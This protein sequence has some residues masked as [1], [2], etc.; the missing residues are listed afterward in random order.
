MS[1]SS[2]GLFDGG[3]ATPKP[4]SPAG[5][6]ALLRCREVVADR[7]AITRRPRMLTPRT[8]LLELVALAEAW[9]PPAPPAPSRRKTTAA[10]LDPLR[11][12][13]AEVAAETI[14][15]LHKD[16]ILKHAESP[17]PE[18]LDDILARWSAPVAAPEEGQERGASVTTERHPSDLPRLRAAADL[19]SRT[20]LDD[21]SL[22]LGQ[23]ARDGGRRMFLL[24]AVCVAI[25]SEL[26]T[27]GWSDPGLR[28]WLAQF[29]AHDV[30]PQLQALTAKRPRALK[31]F[32][33]V[34]GWDPS[35]SLG[36]LSVASLGTR[37]VPD[38]FPEGP[39]VSLTVQ[40][41]DEASAARDAFR[42][43]RRVLDS[44]ALVRPELTASWATP[45]VGVESG[46]FIMSFDV[47][48]WRGS[49]EP[50]DASVAQIMDHPA[51]GAACRYRV[52]AMQVRDPLTRLSLL[53]LGL[54][55]LTALP[56]G[57]VASATLHDLLPR[58]LALH[59]VRT[60][61]EGLARA[62][63]RHPIPAEARIRLG[64]DAGE[65]GE[66]LDRVALLRFLQRASAEEAHRWSQLFPLDV[67]V[68]QW[69]ERTRWHMTGPD[70]DRLGRFFEATRQRIAWQVL[71]LQ[72]AHE[73]VRVDAWPASWIDDLSLHAHNYLTVA[74]LAVMNDPEHLR[75]PSSVL[76]RR[77]GQYDTLLT[78][79]EKSHPRALSA[80]ALMAPLGLVGAE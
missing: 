71:R 11:I 49:V 63:E 31:C 65:E 37:K 46:A 6:L 15:V 68:A 70:P 26:R 30:I 57:D 69:V 75:A 18:M 1:S 56:S 44:V 7:M 22:A 79:L 13:V 14:R 76:A 58:T 55:R 73:R 40:A 72:R 25:L 41:F 51:L 3:K 23:L 39:Y 61:I 36:S 66:D 53:W 5:R 38:G 24:S 12:M 32:I 64:A 77:A 19:L 9:R 2:P 59:K 4:A 74:L 42:Q 52:Q 17:V 21:A 35:L 62:I 45:S 10:P 16:P 29:E 34:S 47:G 50:L 67:H 60:E 80:E 28:A 54:E 78:L 33:P 43:A 48:A 8:A 20:Y 27:R